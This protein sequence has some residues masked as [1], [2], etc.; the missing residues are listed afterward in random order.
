[1]V[2]Q[3]TRKKVLRKINKLDNL[4]QKNCRESSFKIKNKKLKET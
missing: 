2:F 4:F 3:I 1:M